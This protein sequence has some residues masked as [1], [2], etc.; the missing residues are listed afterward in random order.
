M[1]GHISHH[2]S[3]HF[4][5]TNVDDILV[6]TVFYSQ[7]NGTLRKRHIVAGQ[8]LGFTAL[9]LISML[10]L[11]PIAIGI[12]KFLHCDDEVEVKQLEKLGVE[13]AKSSLLSG[14]FSRQTFSVTAVTFANGGD[15]I[16]IY[17]PL[18]ASSS[19]VRILVLLGVFFVLLA[20]WC[21]AG[22]RMARQP[23]VAQPSRVTGTFSCHSCWR[24]WDSTSWWRA[25]LSVYSDC[26]H[27]GNES[28]QSQ[29]HSLYLVNGS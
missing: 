18:F 20:V 10:G 22:Y 12:N 16:G 26:S 8:Y 5:A 27:P 9:V 21:Y 29:S 11:L 14:L 13:A 1:D 19:A 7:V 24:R 15:N 28:C 4:H 25:A 2:R 6:L 3:C 17:S 23:T